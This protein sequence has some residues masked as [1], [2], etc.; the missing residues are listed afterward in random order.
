MDIYI[1]I[2]V[3]IERERQIDI[4]IN[5]HINNIN[6]IAAGKFNINIPLKLLS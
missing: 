3:Y 4:D 2:Y 6:M 1:Y 5:E